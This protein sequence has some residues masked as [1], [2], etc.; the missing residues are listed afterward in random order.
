MSKL[1]P[2]NGVAVLKRIE[3]EEV[4]YGNIVLPDMGKE[5][6]E[7]CEV[8]DFSDT[9]NWHLGNYVPSNLI[10]GKRVLIPKMGSMKV[11]ID[12]EDYIL[13]KETEVLAILEN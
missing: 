7:V 12:G 6:P 4:M 5:L 9:Y 1:K 2:L 8:V 11:T 3:E 13:I 10:K